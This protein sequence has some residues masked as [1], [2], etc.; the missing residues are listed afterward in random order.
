MSQMWYLARADFG[1]IRAVATVSED[2]FSTKT[3]KL[4]TKFPGLVTSGRHNSAMITNAENSQTNG[5]PVGCLV[6]IFTVKINSKSFTWAVCHT[7]RRYFPH[8]SAT[9]DGQHGRLAES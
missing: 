2:C 3:Q 4:L 5:L 1:V 6:F 8:F 7:Q 9:A